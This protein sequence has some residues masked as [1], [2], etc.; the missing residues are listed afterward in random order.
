MLLLNYHFQML[1]EGL[2]ILLTIIALLP[3]LDWLLFDIR[4]IYDICI[5]GILLI[6][7]TKSYRRWI[8]YFFVYIIY[9]V[10]A[11]ILF[12]HIHNPICIMISMIILSL[13]VYYVSYKISSYLE[14]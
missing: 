13:N 7:L 5:V 12:F 6:T 4:F 11:Q 14:V 9:T 3:N 8:L 2:S 10:I 1:F